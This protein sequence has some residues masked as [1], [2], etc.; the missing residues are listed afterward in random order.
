MFGCRP[1]TAKVNLMWTLEFWK[2]L[3]E[4]AVKTTAQA[5]LLGIGGNLVNFW[6]LDPK[7]VAGLALGGLLTSALTSLASN[8]LP[9]GNPG[10]ASMTKAVES[11]SGT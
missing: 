6:T 7:Q 3:A 11:T 1:P 8:A 2:D 5:L 4:R 10:T 9:F